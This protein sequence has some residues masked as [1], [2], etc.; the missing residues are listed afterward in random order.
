MTDAQ[1]QAPP[2]TLVQ[3]VKR[4]FPLALLLGFLGAFFLSGLHERLTLDELALRY[5]DLNVFIHE[6]YLAATIVSIGLYMLITAS[7]IPIA[8]L[9]SVSI[10]MMFGW[11]FGT[12]IIVVGATLGAGILYFIARSLARDFFT[13]RAGKF[14]NVMAEGFRKNAVSYMLFLRLAAIFP[15]SVVN[16]VPAVLGVSFP[17]YFWTTALGIIP[18]TLAYAYA[19]EGLRSIIA[20]RAQ[21]C[22]NN[23]AP[24][25]TPLSASD[26]ITK[27]MLIAFILLS[28]VSLLPVV[29]QKLAKKS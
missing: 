20:E 29:L 5:T 3:H 17:V 13:R 26:I 2:T 27:E 4:W 14:L 28:L 1:H 19:G 21:A 8:L 6:N 22:A 23:V 24:C 10:G 12:F 15:F 7:S 18:G 11:A 9:L 25:G 16:V